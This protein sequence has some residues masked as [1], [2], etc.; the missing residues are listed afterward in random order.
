MTVLD[1][2]FITKDERTKD[3][4]TKDGQAKLG[5]WIEEAADA[6]YFSGRSAYI[7][8][9]Y[10]DSET[11]VRETRKIGSFGVLHPSVLESFDLSNPTTAIEINLE[12]F[13]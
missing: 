9:R 3:E 1:T 12:P 13:V 2:R 4:Q 8:L 7:Y 10:I 5:Y 6:T 11:N